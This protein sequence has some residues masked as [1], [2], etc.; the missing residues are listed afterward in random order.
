MCTLIISLVS[1]VWPINQPMLK[2]E[3]R[4]A[5][6]TN[7]ANVCDVEFLISADILW[8]G[9]GRGGLHCSDPCSWTQRHVIFIQ[10]EKIQGEQKEYLSSYFQFFSSFLFFPTKGEPGEKGQK[11]APGRPGRVGPPGEPGIGL[12]LT[13]REENI[14]HTHASSSLSF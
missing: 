1:P 7:G 9:L 5:L 11:G 8:A 10:I 6:T 14:V 2:N 12:I 4:Q 3:R 13:A